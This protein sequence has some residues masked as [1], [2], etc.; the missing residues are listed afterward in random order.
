MSVQEERKLLQEA[1]TAVGDSVLSASLETKVRLFSLVSDD[2]EVPIEAFAND[3]FAPAGESSSVG[4]QKESAHSSFD[5]EMNP[6]AEATEN[7]ANTSTTRNASTEISDRNETAEV[8]VASVEVN[9]V[10]PEVTHSKQSS[11]SNNIAAK[12]E[13]LE[14]HQD[15]PV[16][17][18]TDPISQEDLDALKPGTRVVIYR[19]QPNADTEYWNATIIKRGSNKKDGQFQIRFDGQKRTRSEW[20]TGDEIARLL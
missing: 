3:G 7:S 19:Q 15:P 8:I 2:F 11:S 16:D 9:N 13:E 14:A 4:I 18:D 5:S 6:T 1:V 20:V 17:G 10:P 12:N